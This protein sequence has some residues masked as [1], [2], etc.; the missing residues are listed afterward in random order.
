M[1]LEPGGTSRFILSQR[2]VRPRVRNCLVLE[3]RTSWS[4]GQ[5]PAGPRVRDHLIRES[6]G[7]SWS[8]K[9]GPAG[10]RVRKRLIRE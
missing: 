10:P 6:G 5:G 4:I 3:S 7:T 1:V 2:Q 9:Q 8:L